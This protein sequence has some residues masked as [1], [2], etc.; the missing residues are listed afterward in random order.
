[1]VN[2][3]QLPPSFARMVGGVAGAMDQSASNELHP[4]SD[5]RMSSQKSTVYLNKA[6]TLLASQPLRH[7]YPQVQSAPI[8][9]QMILPQKPI[10]SDI[11]VTQYI[12]LPKPVKQVDNDQLATLKKALEPINNQLEKL[13]VL[14]GMV[15]QQLSKNDVQPVY[16]PQSIPVNVEEKDD[17]QVEDVDKEIKKLEKKLRNRPK[18]PQPIDSEEDVIED[19]NV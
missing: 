17:A 13:C 1:M 15:Y 3:Q 16:Q 5:G 6:K 8:Q 18:P 10:A 19:L 9:Q 7:V 11:D 4:S 2:G 12:G 14:I